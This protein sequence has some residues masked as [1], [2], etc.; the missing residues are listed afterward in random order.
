MDLQYKLYFRLLC[1]SG[2]IGRRTRLRIWRVKPWGFESPLSHQNL[3]S[4]REK[5]S[6]C[7]F[8]SWLYSSLDKR[9]SGAPRFSFRCFTEDV[10]GIVSILGERCSNQAKAICIGVALW[11]WATF[12]PVN[13]PNPELFAIRVPGGAKLVRFNRLNA[14]ARNCRYRASDHNGKFLCRPKSRL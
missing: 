12:C 10:P 9:R 14:S 1:E 7:T 6:S 3:I 5:V 13:T 4:Y 8:A 11:A 2:G